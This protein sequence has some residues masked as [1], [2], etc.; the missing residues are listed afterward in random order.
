MTEYP[1][2]RPVLNDLDFDGIHADTA[3]AD[4]VPQILHGIGVETTLGTVDEK[5]MFAETPE[6]LFDMFSVVFHV[7]RKD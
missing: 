2:F 1:G 4:D 3:G 7:V 6:H 5:S